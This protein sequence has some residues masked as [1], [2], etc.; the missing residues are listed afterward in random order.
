MN[1]LNYDFKEL[2]SLRS[3]EGSEIVDRFADVTK[4]RFD[5]ADGVPVVIGSYDGKDLPLLLAALGRS[6][7]P[8]APVVVD[9]KPG[10]GTI[11]KHAEAMGAEVIDEK[12]PGQMS[13]VRTGIE[14]ASATYPD[15]CILIT[16]DDCL[17]PAQWAETMTRNSR[18]S[19]E[20]GGIA[21]GGVILEHGESSTTDLLR[22]TYALA[23]NIRRKL[24]N[25][26][27]KARGPN[28]ILQPDTHGRILEELHTQAPDAFPCDV[29]VQESVIKAGGEVT[30]ILSPR[31][32][33]LTRGDRF[34][35]VGGLVKDLAQRGKNRSKL[36]ES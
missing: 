8:L 32:F 1:R 33:T 31:G 17:P 26:L 30:S 12:I 15:S 16:D 25:S 4:S 3:K 9:N 6:S 20:L 27:P 19:R 29:V 10:Q 36:Y 35:S 13:A 14:H 22:T 23:T 2:F 5:H 18:L 28:G 24:T 34:N 11:R 21:Y 7:I